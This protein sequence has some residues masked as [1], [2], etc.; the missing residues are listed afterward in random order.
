MSPFGWAQPRVRSLPEGAGA[1]AEAATEQ[2]Y[3]PHTG[4]TEVNRTYDVML[5]DLLDLCSKERIEILGLVIM[6]ES[7]T[8]RAWYPEGTTGL[9][10][11]YTQGLAA[12]YGTRM[13]D[14]NNWLPDSQFLDHH[15]MDPGA[16]QLSDRLRAEF[17]RPW[18]RNRF[19]R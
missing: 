14:A 2:A 10:R 12:E 8:F 18:M 16:E 7:S 1:G 5:R 17:I 13:I 15:V 4:F 3:R 11:S 6:P 19:G 9:I